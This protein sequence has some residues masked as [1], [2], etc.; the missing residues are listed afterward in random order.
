MEKKINTIQPI[1]TLYDAITDSP[2]FRTN[3]IRYD[4]Q[5]EHLE[6]W[7]DSFS[8]QLKLYTEK[9]NKLNLETELVCQKAI[10]EGLD[11]T[12]LDPHFTGGV[13]KCFSDTLQTSLTFKAKLISSLEES[14]ISPLQQFVKT[15][16]KEF[17]NF[18]KLHEKALERYE[19]HL[20]KYSALSKTKEPSAIREEAF[21][22]FDARKNYVRLS[23]QQVLRVLNFRS[24]LEHCLIERFSA[25]TIA[26]KEFYSDVQVWANLD[27]A[28][29]YWK[30]WLVDDKATCLYQLSKQQIA[31]KRLE[32]EYINLTAPDH[33]LTKYV[34]PPPVDKNKID[35]S[36]SKWGYLFV[37]VSRH[38]WVRRWVYLHGGYIGKCHID[39]KHKPSITRESR[40]R[41]EDCEIS[42]SPDTDRRFC[43]EITQAKQQIATVL[44]AETEVE[45]Q[46][47]ISSFNTNKELAMKEKSYQS[48][49]SSSGSG[50]GLAALKR[51]PT[52]IKSKSNA[53]TSQVSADTII[54]SPTKSSPGNDS[55]SSIYSSTSNTSMN[56]SY[57]HLISSASINLSDDQSPSIVMVST[58]PDAEASLSNSSSLT[59]LLVWEASKIEANTDSKTNISQLPSSS[60]GIPLALVP[61]MSMVPGDEISSYNSASTTKSTLANGARVIWPASPTSIDIP[62]VEGISGYTEKMGKEN[63]ELRCLFGGVDSNE[64]VL[65][66]FVCCLRQKPQ[67]PTLTAKDIELSKS[68]SNTPIV[69]LYENELVHELTQK[70]LESPSQYG[71]AYTGRGFIT[72]E[73]FWFYSCVL[74]TCI[75]SVAVRLRDIESVNI[76]KDT[77]LNKTLG[78]RATEMNSDMAISITLV[79]DAKSDI[80][81]PLIFGT[82]T[83]NIDAVVEKLKFAIDNAK[84]DEPMQI[85][86]SFN[87]M[88]TITNTKTLQRKIVLDMPSTFSKA[89]SPVKSG[90]TIA[91]SS[92]PVSKRPHASTVSADNRPHTLG[93]IKQPLVAQ[94]PRGESEPMAT[95]LP[96]KAITEPPKYI[97]PDMPPSHI[98]VP[99]SMVECGCDDHLDKQ[100]IQLNLP[101]SAKRLYELMFSDEQTSTPSTDG[102]V[103]SD[104]TA[105][106][107]G[108]DLS[109]TKWETID[110]KSQR[111]LKYWMP[112]AN[113]IVR[114][115][116]A[117]VVEQ[118][119]LINKEDYIR[120]TVQISTKTAALPYADAFIPSV[121]YCITW[122]SASECQ[123]TCYL[124]VRWVKS[125]FV[126]TIVTR[127]ALKGMADSVGVFGPI[128]EREANRIHD[129]VEE[130]R[131][132]RKKASN[133]LAASPDTSNIEL[134][135]VREEEA[136][137]SNIT[138]VEP[139]GETSPK[140]SLEISKPRSMKSSVPPVEKPSTAPK[141]VPQMKKTPAPVISKPVDVKSTRPKLTKKSSKQKIAPNIKQSYISW[142]SSAKEYAPTI[143]WISLATYAFLGLTVYM[144]WTWFW[145]TSKTLERATKA[146]NNNQMDAP[147][148]T[149]KKSV[150]RSVYL[151]DLEKGFLSASIRPPYVDSQSYT[152]F[153]QSRNDISSGNNIDTS[154][155]IISTQWYNVEHYRLALDLEVSRERIAMLRHDMLTIF[156]ILNKLDVQLVESEYTNWLLDTRL[157]CKYYPQL[158]EDDA[159]SENRSSLC[160][161]VKLQLHKLF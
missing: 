121:R 57:S 133:V 129:S 13:M 86:N 8:R 99:E 123:L 6:H 104:K 70:G 106:I 138:V 44:Q 31:R 4:Q 148:R 139:E 128:L 58:T 29:A 30:E 120:Y 17:K 5:L 32:D 24:S 122:V 107:E 135:L 43:F 102:G 118:Q 85:R 158:P 55:S 144:T 94:R 101:I 83:D 130:T 152:F 154:N 111:T 51:F 153:L 12:L 41:L 11:E 109:A 25:A 40:L 81:E 59:P 28:I 82:L 108:H 35:F 126:K 33:S 22:L 131:L 71:Y 127:A 7:L 50:K 156:Q 61:A 67:S 65:D 142:L 113:P 47:W 87:K 90:D 36:N 54:N 46:A 62:I 68:V 125:V 84:S 34:P 63:Q 53:T 151:R 146:I 145:S 42:A 112:V 149:E 80:K 78:A 15:N 119:I 95:I 88:Q 92:A 48:S 114:M 116:E 93:M 96:V 27:A 39:T 52:I 115:K 56:G 10:P 66:A 77:S 9:L 14:L 75:N 18:R 1:F 161:D 98:E 89:L 60:W 64:V 37:R 105:A 159:R 49:K 140:T 157:K 150:A 124:G 73:S 74:M 160:N 38:N 20:T 21:R 19:S 134:N 91:V 137:V 16:I 72:Q 110:G 147:L 26:H 155:D 23:G 45:M 132:L 3:V 79:P 141:T 2:V 117:E 69:D 97:D 76:I 103:W 143:S 136:E 100:D